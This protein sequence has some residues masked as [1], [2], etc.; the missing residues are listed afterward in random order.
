MFAPISRSLGRFGDLCA[1]YRAPPTRLEVRDSY[2]FARLSLRI[3][4]T[5]R[6]GAIAEDRPPGFCLNAR[7]ARRLLPDYPTA[8]ATTHDPVKHP[9]Q[10]SRNMPC[11]IA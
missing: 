1:R 4:N 10:R 11:A 9:V 5:N 6:L 3:H 2:A 8:C 7:S